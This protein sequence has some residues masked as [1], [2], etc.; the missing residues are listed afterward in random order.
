MT[1]HHT[2]RCHPRQTLKP[3]VWPLWWL[4][5]IYLY[6]DGD[7]VSFVFNWWNPLSWPTA[8]SLVAIA[9]LVQGAPETWRR[10][11]DVGLRVSPYF[12]KNNIKPEWLMPHHKY[13]TPTPESSR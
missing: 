13:V 2:L 12:K 11:E 8:I 3:V 9:V 6:K 7:V 1:K 4:H 5:V 10:R